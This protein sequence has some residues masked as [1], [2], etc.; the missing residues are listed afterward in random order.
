MILNRNSL[1][2]LKI[3]DKM[4]DLGLN[5]SYYIMIFQ[6]IN[7]ALIGSATAK[8]KVSYKHAIRNQFPVNA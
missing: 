7:D 4:E 3:L 8:S 2:R 6:R 5:I 1:F